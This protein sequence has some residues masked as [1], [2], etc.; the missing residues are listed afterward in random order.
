MYGDTGFERGTVGAALA[1]VRKPPVVELDFWTED[2]DGDG[3][4]SM[5]T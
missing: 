3:D 4:E 5:K 1:H 2:G